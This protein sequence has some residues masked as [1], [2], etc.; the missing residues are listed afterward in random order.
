MQMYKIEELKRQLPTIQTIFPTKKTLERMK[1]YSNMSKEE[2][3]AELNVNDVH[4]NEFLSNP[5]LYKANA[6]ELEN[7]FNSGKAI[8]KLAHFPDI[9]LMVMRRDREVAENSL[10]KAGIDE[11]EARVFEDLIQE[12]SKET[13]TYSTKGKLISVKNSGHCIYVDCPNS[14]IDAIEEVISEI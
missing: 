11:G 10:I 3:V 9:P 13:S 5:N 6:S 2:L 7:M 1:K 14:V 8:E 12:L 4:I